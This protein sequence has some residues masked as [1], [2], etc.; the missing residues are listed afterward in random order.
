LVKQEGLLEKQLSYYTCK[1]VLT[2]ILFAGGIAFLIVIDCPWL[3]ALNAAYLAFVFVQIGFLGHDAGHRQVFRDPWKNDLLGFAAMPLIGVSCSWWRQTHDWHHRRPNQ[4]GSDPA[5]DYPVLAFCDEQAVAKRGFGRFMVRYQAYFLIP[6]AALYALSARVSSVRSLR[7]KG[8]KHQLIETA[9][10][11]LHFTPY[12]VLVFC[13]LG[14][15]YGLLF[16]TIHQA[17]FG[18]FGVSVFAPNHKG[19]PILDE[20]HRLD[21]LRHQVLTARNVTGHYLIDLWFGGLNYQ[22]EHHLFPSMPRNKLKAARTIVKPFCQA[23]GIDY[24]EVGLLRSYWD[25]LQDLHR[26]SNRLRGERA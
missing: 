25:V 16:I 9:L 7:G 6:L 1:I 15:G 23:N 2:L 11:G 22:I 14:L 13:R 24:C 17:L 20:S 4:I 5:I 19:Q 10:L 26:I 3:Q 18:V 12:F 21:H 8:A